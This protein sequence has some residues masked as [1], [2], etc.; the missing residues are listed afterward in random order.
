MLLV[1]ASPKNKIKLHMLKNTL[2]FICIYFFSIVLT[3]GQNLPSLNYSLKECIDYA[4]THQT[5]V[6]NA[7]ID[8]LSASHKVREHISTGFPQINSSLEVNDFLK[9]PTTL[10]PAEF[11]G[12]PRGTF[13]PLQ[14]GTK[15][16]STLGLQISQL[17]FDGSFFVGIQ[18]AKEYVALTKLSTQKSKIDIASNVSKAYYMALAA[19]KRLSLLDAN[20]ER[21]EKLFADT[22]A[23]NEAGFA[24]KIDVDRVAVS[25][26]N[27]KTEKEKAQR[28]TALSV[29]VLKLQMG[30]P[31]HIEL[32]LTET[33]TEDVLEKFCKDTMQNA[34]LNNRI[35]Y[36]LLRK[37]HELQGLNV[38]RLKNMYYPTLNAYASLQTQAFRQTF[39]FLDTKERW[40]AISVIGFKLSL[41]IF[42]GFRKDAMIKQAHLDQIKTENQIQQLQKA[43][44]FEMVNAKAN[45]SNHLKTLEIQKRNM[46]LALEVTKVAELKYKE[47]V[48]SNLEVVTAETEYKTAQTNYINTLMD[49][50]IA[51]I[52]LLKAQG[53]LYN[54]P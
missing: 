18:A 19:Q 6:L 47:G 20:L 1:G 15:Y 29:S 22:R 42:D 30:L 31:Q 51:R 4:I 33:I 40:F 36:R 3:F 27:L 17:I 2:L 13:I 38:K 45:F 50:Y 24:E 12:G 44:D 14:F 35:E 16:N 49:L 10:V 54:E 25:L 23:M 21:L 46:D 34:S 7:Q 52:D 8:E 26:N 37:N 48:G 43:V 39:N 53:I 11:A 5:D 28:L 9:I 32:R 41:P